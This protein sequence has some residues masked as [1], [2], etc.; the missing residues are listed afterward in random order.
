MSDGEWHYEILRNFLN[1]TK[2]DEYLM[3]SVELN[4]FKI[5]FQRH[6]ILAANKY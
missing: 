3:G 5:H 6:L 4:N 1:D 2:H